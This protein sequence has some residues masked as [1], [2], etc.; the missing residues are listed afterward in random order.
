MKQV[1]LILFSFTFLSWAA[2]AD[3]I[4]K[5]LALEGEASV[6][7]ANGQASALKI[8][9]PVFTPNACE[10]TTTLFEVPVLN[11]ISTSWSRINPASKDVAWEL[12][13]SS[14]NKAK[15]VYPDESIYILPTDF[16]FADFCTRRRRDYECSS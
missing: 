12:L 4:G 8:D 15:I 13:K 5:V 1:V 7:R 16:Y 11:I 2:A 9:S 10:G 14:I 6:T 3:P